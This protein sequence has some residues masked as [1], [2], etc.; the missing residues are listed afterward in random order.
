MRAHRQT[1]R[2]RH[3]SPHRRRDDASGGRGL[4]SARHKTPLRLPAHRRRDDDDGHAVPRTPSRIPR[5]GCPGRTALAAAPPW[6]GPLRPCPAPSKALRGSP[7]RDSGYR[8]TAYGQHSAR[9]RMRGHPARAPPPRAVGA[10]LHPASPRPPPRGRAPSKALLGSPRHGSRHRST[11]AAQSFAPSGEPCGSPR[12]GPA[13][14]EAPERPPC[15]A[16]PG[17]PH[18]EGPRSPR[19]GPIRDPAAPGERRS[20]APSGP[21]AGRCRLPHWLCNPP[22]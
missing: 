22:R 10:F 4:H 5:R 20:S 11:L 15:A 6:A 21:W 1:A 18:P 8:S 12:P 13:Q 2:R 3:R 16:P 9:D 19:A 17:W 14:S 7:R